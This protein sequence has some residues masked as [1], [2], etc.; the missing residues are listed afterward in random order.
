MGA[1]SRASRRCWSTANLRARTAFQKLE[2]F[3]EHTIDVLVGE[4]DVGERGA[5]DWSSAR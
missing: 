1:S 4:P 5:R 3:H 2:R